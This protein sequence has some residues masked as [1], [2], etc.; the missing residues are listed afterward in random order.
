MGD[1]A[2]FQIQFVN[3][4]LEKPTAVA[5]MWFGI[6]DFEFAEH[7]AVMRNLTGLFIGLH[8]MRYNSVILDIP[9]A[10]LQ[11]PHLSMQAK[12]ADEG[13]T[14]KP[15]AVMTP[16]DKTIPPMTTKAINAHANYTSQFKTTGIITPIEQYTEGATLL[17]SHSMS[18]VTNKEVPIRVT[19]TSESPDTLK[20][21]TQIAHFAVLTPEQSKFI[22]PVDTAVLQMLPSDDLDLTTYLNELLKSNKKEPQESNFWFP[23]PKNPG[24]IVE[25]SPL[26]TRILNKLL[27]LRRKKKLNAQDDQESKVQFLKQFSWTDALLTTDEQQMVEEIL[28]EYHDI[29][30]RHRMNI[31]MNT[32]FT[33]KLTPKNDKPVYSQSLPMPT[34]VKE[35]VLLELAVLHKYGIITV[36]PFWKSA[37]PIFAQRKP[38]RKLGLL[39]DLRNINSLISDDYI[40]NNHPVSTLSDTAQHLAGKSLFCKLDCSQAYYCLQMAEQRSVEMLAFSFASRTFTYKR[41]AQGLSRTLSAISSFMR[42]YLD[43]VVKADQCAQNVDDIGIAANSAAELSG[44]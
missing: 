12:T 9:H 36:L 8:F 20:K 27:E 32:E 29:F 25:H 11:F 18:T 30:A 1:P 33:V 35:D 17:I 42:E 28:V 31:G 41:L 40:N 43:P 34:H 5:T 37:S 24:N 7:F 22:K 23:T 44:T 21:N 14:V 2:A 39:V 16:E 13:K 4:Q 15:Q 3:N 19:N 26:Q 6:S 38:N 10:L